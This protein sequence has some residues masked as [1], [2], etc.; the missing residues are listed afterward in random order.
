MATIVVAPQFR[1]RSPQRPVRDYSY[2][3]ATQSFN[4]AASLIG[5][6]RFGLG[7]LNERYESFVGR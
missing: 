7:R 3:R 2:Q 1:P 6:S 4:I 5:G